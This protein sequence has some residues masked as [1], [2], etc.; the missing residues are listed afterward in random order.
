MEGFSEEKC[1]EESKKT[2]MAG[3]MLQAGEAAWRV[4]VW[5]YYG[6]MSSDDNESTGLA[7]K[8]HQGW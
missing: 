5:K 1:Q 4:Q 8:G 2:N 3:Y 6:V 7:M